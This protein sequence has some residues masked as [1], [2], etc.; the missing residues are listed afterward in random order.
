MHQSQVEISRGQC[1]HTFNSI[2]G[3]IAAQE[4]S[5]STTTKPEHPN[6]DEAQENDLK[7]SFMKRK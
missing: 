2:K 6:S 7:N 3:S 1:E 4:T 5:G